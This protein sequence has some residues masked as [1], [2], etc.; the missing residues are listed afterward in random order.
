MTVSQSE[1]I[2]THSGSPACVENV[3]LVG[4]R[5]MELFC[6]RE[7]LVSCFLNNKPVRCWSDYSDN[8]EM[9]MLVNVVKGCVLPLTLTWYAELFT[10]REN[11]L[12]N[13]TSGTLRHQWPVTFVSLMH[14][15]STARG[16]LMRDP[17]NR[18]KYPLRTTLI[19]LLTASA[20]PG[21]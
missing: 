10:R 18:Y 3:A 1:L 5:C 15:W 9:L 2:I 20:F 17:F 7:T 6:W 21:K 11:I 16:S 8:H 4:A 13:G 14:A 19:Q 12:R